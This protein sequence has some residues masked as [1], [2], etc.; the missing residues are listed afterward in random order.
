MVASLSIWNGDIKPLGSLTEVWVQIT[1]IPPKWVDWDTL[2]EV[3]SGIDMMIEVDWHS[4]F[5]SFFSQARVKV[6]CKNLARIPKE[7]IFVFGIQLFKIAFKPKG[8]I[9]M[10]DLSEARS[11]KG[12][13]DIDP[14]EEDLLDE[15]LNDK[16]NGKGTGPANQEGSAK[17]SSESVLP[18]GGS[19]GND[20]QP[21]GTSVRRV[22]LFD[23]IF[24]TEQDR[25]RECVNLLKVMELEEGQ[26]EVTI[27][28][29][30]VFEELIKNNGADNEEVELVNLPEEWVYELQQR[31]IN[32][33][34][35]KEVNQNFA[36]QANLGLDGV[37]NRVTD[38]PEFEASDAEN[39]IMQSS[40][41][42]VDDLEKV[43]LNG[44]LKG[45][46]A[47]KKQ[48]WGPV[49]P[50]RRSSRNIDDGR[51]MMEKAQE[52]KRKWNMEENAS[53]KK[54]SIVTSAARLLSVAKDIGVVVQ[55]GNPDLVNQMLEVD[56][57]RSKDSMLQCKHIPCCG[58]SDLG[59]GAEDNMENSIQVI[60]LNSVQII[61]PDRQ[62]TRTGNVD[63]DLDDQEQAGP[64]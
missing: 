50:L 27:E 14:E 54:L 25:E 48:Q 19:Q 43:K 35:N 26:V 47:V 40:Q 1:S 58:A 57:K 62:H 22:L 28:E 34:D 6:Q 11:E 12:D 51:T 32:G 17:G 13:D 64:K 55:D 33:N 18:T 23:E 46:R 56:N 15:E 21:R 3:V 10:E 49:I 44:H 16:A 2:R 38:V 5:N 9:Q 30:L 60:S 42:T 45:K 59:T 41:P 31:K 63:Q 29:P 20:T 37:H 24:T 4:L 8:Y 61:S 53:N 7:R 52:A 39:I 36:N